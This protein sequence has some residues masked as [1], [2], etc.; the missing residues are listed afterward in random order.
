MLI[1]GNGGGMLIGARGRTPVV[2]LLF[3]SFFL[4]FLMF[5]LFSFFVFAFFCTPTSSLVKVVAAVFLFFLFSALFLFLLLFFAFFGTTSSNIIASSFSF[6]FFS[7][8]AIRSLANRSL[9]ISISLCF[10]IAIF[11]KISFRIFSFLSLGSSSYS[12]GSLFPF[13]AK[14]QNGLGLASSLL[15]LGPQPTNGCAF[16]SSSSSW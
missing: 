1:V 6:L 11:S 13:A 2:S 15:L 10:S 8:N 5:L 4:M 16:T 12:S 14:G 7:S 3:G 9:S